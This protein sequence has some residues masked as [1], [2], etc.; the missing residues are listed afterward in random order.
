M[1]ACSGQCVENRPESTNFVRKSG[2]FHYSNRTT[3]LTDLRREMR[4]GAIA[5]PPTAADALGPREEN[6]GKP[7]A[8]RHARASSFRKSGYVLSSSLKVERRFARTA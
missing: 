4:A 6:L 2:D 8:S 1:R 7:G 3:V 5:A